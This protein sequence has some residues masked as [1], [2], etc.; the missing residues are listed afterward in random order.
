MSFGDFFLK[1]PKVFG[2]DIGLEPWGDESL[3][4][5]IAGIG[6]RFTGLSQRQVDRV[7]KRYDGFLLDDPADHLTILTEIYRTDTELF[8]PFD[9]RGWTYTLEMNHQPDRLRIVRSEWLADIDCSGNLTA[10]L[11]TTTEHDVLFELAFGN[12]LRI[13]TA[14]AALL[15]GGIMLHSAGISDGERA[16]IGFGHSGAGKST[17]SGL[18]L[19][20]GQR[21]LSDDTNVLDC[22]Q[23]L[24]RAQRL[25]FAGDLGPT[26][27]DDRAVPIASILHLRQG[28]NHQQFQI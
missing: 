16:W 2:P 3:A 24:W 17:L 21:V 4:I 20:A 13:L 11:W 7:R 25:P 5:G 14:Y 1:N 28:P 15:R 8:R 19:E 12:V 6:F 22:N 10:S 18:A 27:G 9:K 23:G 26:H